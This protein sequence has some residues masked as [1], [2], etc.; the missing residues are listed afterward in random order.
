MAE[1]IGNEANEMKPVVDSKMSKRD[2]IF[3]GF[4]F[5]G[6]VV[7]IGHAALEGGKWVKGKFVDFKEK[8]AEKKAQKAEKEN[9]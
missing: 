1:M 8:R 5:T 7:G 6:A 3:T 2:K 9:E 4:C